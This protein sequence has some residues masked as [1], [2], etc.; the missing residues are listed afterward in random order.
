VRRAF[1]RRVHAKLFLAAALS[2][3]GVPLAGCTDDPRT[4]AIPTDPWYRVV[5][6]QSHDFYPL[7]LFLFSPVKPELVDEAAA[8]MGNVPLLQLSTSE[9]Q[10]YATN[11][12]RTV[13]ELRPFLIHGLYRTQKVFTVSIADRALWVDSAD[14][15]LDDAPVRRQPLVVYIDE[16]PPDVYVTIAWAAAHRDETTAAQP[17]TP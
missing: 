5:D 17:R 11:E 16:V 13:R 4:T 2:A 8:A 9:A 10:R 1:F 3:V 14:D 12:L 6:K 15:P 7:P